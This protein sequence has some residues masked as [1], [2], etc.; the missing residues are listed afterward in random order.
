MQEIM[1][2]FS[3]VLVLDPAQKR[4]PCHVLKSWKDKNFRPKFNLPDLSVG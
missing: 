3:I 1:R 4:I 2:D